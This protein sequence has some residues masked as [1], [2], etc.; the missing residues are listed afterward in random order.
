MEEEDYTCAICNKEISL[1]EGFMAVHPKCSTIIT[2]AR[3]LAEM[4]ERV[5]DRTMSIE[6]Y[7][8]FVYALSLQAD[9]V[10]KPIEPNG[11]DQTNG[12]AKR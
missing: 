4:V 11:K 10:L 12:T 7:E 3:T 2:E 6:E 8:T 5:K 9:K 1:A